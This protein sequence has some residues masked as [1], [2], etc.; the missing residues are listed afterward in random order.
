MTAQ[1]EPVI[2]ALTRISGDIKLILERTLTLGGRLDRA[3]TDIDYLKSLT[4]TLKEGVKT[5]KEAREALALGLEKA[6]EAR[7]VKDR[8]AAEALRT[9]DVQRW[10]PRE[11]LMQTVLVVAALAG[12]TISYFTRF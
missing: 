4:Q 8:E 11:R 9:K 3:E 12:V 5:D 7:R 6:E 1:D 10:T 2:V